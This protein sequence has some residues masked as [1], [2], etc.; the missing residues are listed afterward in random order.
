MNNS[1]YIRLMPWLVYASKGQ[2]GLICGE[3]AER[4]GES[5]TV[6]FVT[7]AVI[8]PESYSR[9]CDFCSKCVG[10]YYKN[11]NLAA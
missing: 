1:Q 2:F 5:D 8:G 9:T 4:L 7:R 11:K 6:E 3:C 10:D